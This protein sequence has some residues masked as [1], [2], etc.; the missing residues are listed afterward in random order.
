MKSASNIL[1]EKFD[2]VRSSDDRRL[3][4]RELE[5]APSPIAVVTDDELTFIFKYEKLE[6]GLLHMISVETPRQLVMNEKAFIIFSTTT[7]QYALR[8]PL[9]LLRDQI[10]TF[11]IQTELRRLQRRT[12]FRVSTMGTK[13]LKFEAPQLSLNCKGSIFEAIDISAGGMTILISKPA[14]LNLKLGQAFACKLSHPS[15]TIEEIKAVIRHID[16]VEYGQKLGIEFLH[17]TTDQSRALL[18]L[19]LQMHRERLTI[20]DT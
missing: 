3:V 15:R 4:F 5:K 19:S 11:S 6:N 9:K 10:T 13:S 18:A 17:L 14:T 2:I 12:N 8:A 16:M 20:L 7:G 1:F